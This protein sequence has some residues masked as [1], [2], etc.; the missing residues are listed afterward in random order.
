MV[1]VTEDNNTPTVDIEHYALVVPKGMDRKQDAS[2]IM[3]VKRKWPLAMQSKNPADFDSILAKNFTFAGDGQL[4]NRDEYIQDRTAPSEWI[5]THV[6]YDNLTLHFFGDMAL[7]SYQNRVT[8][9]NLLTKAVEIERISWGDMYVKEDGTWKLSTAHVID[10]Q[11]EDDG[12]V[13]VGNNN[14]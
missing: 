11:I 14:D 6:K 10:Y 3:Q 8:N 5:I 4:Y 2:A 13:I 7:L 9:E 1:E 12:S